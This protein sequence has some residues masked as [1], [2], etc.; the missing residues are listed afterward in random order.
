VLGVLG[1]QTARERVVVELREQRG[2]V[3]IER[4]ESCRVELGEQAGRARNPAEG[5]VAG[6]CVERFAQRCRA[7]D[8]VDGQSSGICG[9]Q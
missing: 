7:V 2:G 5:E 9:S 8:R 4:R 1:R 3:V 6:D